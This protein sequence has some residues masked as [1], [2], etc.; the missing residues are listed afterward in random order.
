MDFFKHIKKLSHD[1]QAYLWLMCGAVAVLMVAVIFIS[2]GGMQK[3]NHLLAMYGIV[4]DSQTACVFH[5]NSTAYDTEALIPEQGGSPVST[6]LT[7]SAVNWQWNAGSYGASHFAIACAGAQNGPNYVCTVQQGSPNTNFGACSYPTKTCSGYT[8]VCAPKGGGC[9]AQCNGY[10]YTYDYAHCGNA[11]DIYG[12][13][14]FGASGGYTYTGAQPA[15]QNQ[16]SA[17]SGYDGNWPPSTLTMTAPAAPGTYAYY[18]CSNWLLN[19]NAHNSSLTPLGCLGTNLTVVA[20][21]VSAGATSNSPRTVGQTAT[22]SFHADSASPPTQCAIKN[23]DDSV[24]FKN[25]PGCPSSANASYTTQVFTVPGTYAYKFYYYTGSWTLAQTVNV[26]V[27]PATCGNGLNS[28]A[29]PSCTC[30]VGQVQ[31]GSTC[32]VPGDVC[33]DIPAVQA[34][35]PPGCIGPVPTPS[36]LCVPAGSSWNG[37]ACVSGDVCSNIPGSQSMPPANGY[38]SGGVCSCN[39]GYSLSGGACVAGD[40]CNNMPGVQSSVPAN[41]TQQASGAC[42][43]NSGYVVVGAQCLASGVIQSFTANPSRVRK[44][45]TAA[46]NWAT[47]NMTSCV[48]KSFVSGGT[49]TISLS[50]NGALNPTVNSK[51]IFT[52]TCTDV[53][54]QSY[55]SSATVNLVPET[56]EN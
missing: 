24:I 20:P 15:C 19:A 52:L 42:T 34:S 25:I 39:V 35:V 28:T 40:L 37:S 5:C 56:I 12:H 49:Q 50:L 18:F 31:S 43:A 38:T 48:L 13:A 33:T 45:N 9:S 8:Q 23:F 46:V 32:S 44:G 1:Q 30:P 36:G 55:S 54:G 22:I 27:N 26:V 29:Y 47:S 41:C 3:V 17:G 21:A 53:S 51:T 6:V 11:D 14:C 2:S 4:P 7:N 16:G 10:N